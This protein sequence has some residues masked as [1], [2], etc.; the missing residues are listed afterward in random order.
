VE[1]INHTRGAVAIVEARKVLI[2]SLGMRL[3]LIPAGEFQMGSPAS[4]PD[5]FDEEKPQH[6][7]RITRPF[8]LGATEVT[9]G[10]FRRFVDATGYRTDAERDGLGGFGWDERKGTWVQ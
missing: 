8:Y 1:V 4:D 9:V 3:V 6:R 5:A 10:Q 7:V 2:N